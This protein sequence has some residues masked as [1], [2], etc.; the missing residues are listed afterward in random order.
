ML[1]RRIRTSSLET[2][3]FDK[4]PSVARFAPSLGSVEAVAERLGPLVVWLVV[5][6]LSGL[7]GESDRWERDVFGETV[8]LPSPNGN[9]N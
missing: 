6:C 5:G 8:T 4:L 1:E 3:S 7:V 2:G 9:R